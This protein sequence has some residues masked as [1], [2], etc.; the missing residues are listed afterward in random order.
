MEYLNLTT[1]LELLPVSTT[2]P[3]Q[4]NN[5]TTKMI[6]NITE[7]ATSSP[8]NPLDDVRFETSVNEETVRYN[9]ELGNSSFSYD[10]TFTTFEHVVLTIYLMIIIVV[11]LSANS[12]VV[13]ASLKYASFNLDKVTIL[14]LRHLAITDLFMV[15]FIGM[16][17]LYVHI[18]KRDGSL[19][20]SLDWLCT[21]LGYFYEVLIHSHIMFYMIIAGHRFI[22]CIYPF[23]LQTM[24]MTQGRWCCALIWF[25][26][27]FLFAIFPWIFHSIRN[28]NWM[29]D[30]KA[31][32]FSMEMAMCGTR[33]DKKGWLW[34][35]VVYTVIL[36]GVI[37]S[38][39]ILTL[40]YAIYINR[41][42]KLKSRHVVEARI[43]VSAMS[44]CAILS[45]FWAP[46][47]LAHMI[48]NPG[49][50][51]KYNSV[52]L[53]TMSH[54]PVV[55]A[56]INPLI[57]TIVNKRFKKFLVGELSRRRR[58]VLQGSRVR[59]MKQQAIDFRE[60]GQHFYSG[61]RHS[62]ADAVVYNR[63]NIQVTKISQRG[64]LSAF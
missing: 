42:A 43:T 34:F 56:L 44:V 7:F 6:S 15:I 40:F 63:N 14:F 58:S 3:A 5:A 9:E 20:K 24:S 60:R 11:G 13:Y 47:I 10:E 50:P 59:A 49:E 26:G 37:I 29:S 64:R 19:F 53:K 28:S 45:N 55:T 35:N 27:T 22:R 31:V 4:Q 61:V 54:L 36:M 51:E 23:K 46:Y 12:F 16:P 2:H 57:Y 8:E 1:V 41:K 33:T 38:L 30:H 52:G 18:L 48:A 39:N 25:L 62:I 17:M 32:A 21:M